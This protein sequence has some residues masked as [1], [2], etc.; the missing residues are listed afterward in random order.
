M[1]VGWSSS[2]ASSSTITSGASVRAGTAI[3]MLYRLAVLQ[4]EA[5]RLLRGQRD[6]ARVST[7]A[8]AADRL[9]L[10]VVD[11]ERPVD[12]AGQAGPAGQRRGHQAGVVVSAKAGELE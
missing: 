12:L 1:P 6:G 2:S 9:G 8:A 7:R 10:E 3:G 11:Q 5:Q 4:G